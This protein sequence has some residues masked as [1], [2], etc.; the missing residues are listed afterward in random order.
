MPVSIFDLKGPSV[1]SNVSNAES[2]V[3]VCVQYS[4]Y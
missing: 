1:V 3:G 4:L 2:G